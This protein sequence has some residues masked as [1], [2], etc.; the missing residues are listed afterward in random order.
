MNRTAIVPAVVLAIVL[1]AV[2]RHAPAGSDKAPASAKTKGGASDAAFDR[3]KTLEGEWIEATPTKTAKGKAA[4]IYKLTAGGSA[5]AETLFPDTNHEMLSVYRLDGDSLLLSHYC[6]M[7]NQPLMRAKLG[8]N[9]DEL[10]FQFA[11]GCNIDPAKD[12]YIHDGSIRFVG[13]DRLHTE[14]TYFIDG[15]EAGKHTFDLVRK[16]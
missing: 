13:S 10:V 3:L 7:G 11:G 14:W 9:S 15:K 6:C 4:S 2:C 16:K 12:S 8:A 5:I 1:G